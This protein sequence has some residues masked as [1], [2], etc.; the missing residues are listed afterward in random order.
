[1]Y[2]LH[3]HRWR[4]SKMWYSKN[5]MVY[6][7]YWKIRGC[8]IISGMCR[9][10]REKQSGQDGY[11]P[12]QLRNIS[13][14]YECLLAIY[15]VHSSK[16]VAS[17]PVGDASADGRFAVIALHSISRLTIPTTTSM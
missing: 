15:L 2:I 11:E 7:F 1:M 4:F 14:L 3:M 10:K 9:W 6:D 16:T 12:E 13:H 8:M 5:W 17:Y